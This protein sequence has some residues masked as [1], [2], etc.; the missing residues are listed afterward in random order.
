MGEEGVAGILHE[1]VLEGVVRRLTC[2]LDMAAAAGVKGLVH[3]RIVVAG[4]VVEAVAGEGGVQQGYRP[5][6]GSPVL[7]KPASVASSFIRG[8]ITSQV[9]LSTVTAMPASLASEA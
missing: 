7:P 9:A 4:H 5:K 2:G 6:S 1:L 8:S 3:G